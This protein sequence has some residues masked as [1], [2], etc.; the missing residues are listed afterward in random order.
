M[1]ARDTLAPENLLHLAREIY[2]SFPANARLILKET[3][4]L[5][6]E[7]EDALALQRIWEPAPTSPPSSALP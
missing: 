7:N 6:P 1:L 3:L 5:H 4:R 2:P